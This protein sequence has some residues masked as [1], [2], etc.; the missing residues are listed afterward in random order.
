[1]RGYR[2]ILAAAALASVLAL[3]GC[4]P[5]KTAREAREAGIESLNAGDYEGAIASFEMALNDRKGS[6]GRFEFDVLKYRGEA[7]YRAGDFA[8]AAH[9]YGVLLDADGERAEY[10]NLESMA[11]SGSGDVKEAMAAYESGLEMDKEAPFGEEA[12][13]ALGRALEDQ[14]EYD[15]ALSLYEGGIAAGKDAGR[16]YSRM[17]RCAVEKGDCETALLYFDS[18]EAAG[19]ES[20]KREIAY[21]RAVARE[22]M[23]DFSGALQAFQDY[24]AIYGATPETE[25][26]IAFLKTR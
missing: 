24:E 26:E 7:E 10:Y 3:S 12:L 11:L 21:N 1:M 4:Q 17:G 25:H 15:Q 16:L 18:G 8:A 13:F 14:G 2:K 22:Y 23:G 9:T 20:A 6:A 5:S 19:D